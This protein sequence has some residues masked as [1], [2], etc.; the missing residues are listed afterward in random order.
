MNE[1]ALTNISMQG[2]APIT[3]L[4]DTS[5]DAEDSEIELHDDNK[6]IGLLEMEKIFITGVLDELKVQFSYS[7]QVT[8]NYMSLL[9]ALQWTNLTDVLFSS[10]TAI[11][12]K[13]S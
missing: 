5:S 11:S 3:G 8:L 2:S 4:S 1:K 9:V 10:M 7:Y 6:A 13:R 12:S